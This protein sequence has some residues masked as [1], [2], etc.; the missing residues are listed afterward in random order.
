M[1]KKYTIGIDIG[2]TNT[3]AVLYNNNYQVISYHKQSYPTI[4]TEEGMAE[5]DPNQVFE[6][7]IYVIQQI[8]SEKPHLYNQIK[9]ISFSSAMHSVIFLDNMNEPLSNNI[10]WADNRSHYNVEQFK[11]TVN[12]LS[13][14]KRTGTPIHSMTPFSKILWF[15]ENRPLI[16]KKT[17]KIIGIKEYI[18]FK[19]TND[20]KIDYSIASATG[21]LNIH[22]LEWDEEILKILEISK[23]NLSGLVDVTY[24][25]TK[26][27]SYYS[28]KLGLPGDTKLVIG[29]SDGGLSNLG[30]GAV[31][32][33]EV[34]I[35]IGTSGA[36]RM[37]TDEIIL[38][39][40]GRTFCYYLSKDKWLIG[41]AV[42]NG[43][44]VI[45]WLSSVLYSNED[46][47]SILID[48]N[49]KA[50]NIAPGSDN[51]FFFPYINGERSPIWNSEIRGGF[52]G[53]SSYHTRGHFIKAAMEGV[54]FN[55]YNVW[56]LLQSIGGE[57]VILKATGGFL[58]S[59]LWTQMLADIF[60]ETI[61]I[62]ASLES[63]CLGAILIAEENNNLKLN[64][65]KKIIPNPEM[66]K[67]YQEILPDYQQLN[68][69]F[70]NMES[71]QNR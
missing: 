3:K 40:T 63:S 2:T 5:Q 15:K 37:I 48:M 23:D 59:Q 34:A 60:N 32:P 51:L 44:N 7:V 19:L 20:F 29:A 30:L 55:L 70:V 13:L 54:L 25:W 53:V 6:A 62:P 61:Y 57:A 12:W 45:E 71:I 10:T 43:G 67:E 4:C 66:V 46:T 31:N 33:N 64:N 42:N 41:G 38:D 65:S 1:G 22:E 26:I 58:N 36:V 52:I 56:K 68:N 8:L 28:Q 49:N 47:E 24:E 14:Y 35:T 39:P 16:F 9:F 11:K 18:L 50:K 69:S 17:R 21:L 27:D